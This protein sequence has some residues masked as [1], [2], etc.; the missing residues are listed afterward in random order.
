[1]KIAKIYTERSNLKIDRPFSYFISDE[2]NVL[3]GTRVNINFNGSDIVGYVEDIEYSD[4]SK[5]EYEDIQGFELKE[6]SDVIDDKPLLNKELVDLTHYL[7]KTTLSS[8]I[9]CYQTILPPSLRPNSYKKVNIK[10]NKAVR[11]INNNHD[12]T[13]LNEKDLELISILDKEPYLVDLK[14]YLSNIKRLEKL[15][16]VEKF[17]KEVLRNPLDKNYTK[18]K[19]YDLTNEQK[20]VIDEINNSNDQVYL[21]EGVTGSGKTEVYI[22]LSKEVLEQGKNVLVL[23]PEVSLTSQMVQRYMERFDYEIAIFHSKLSSGEKY[24]EYRRIRDDKVRIVIGARSACF[25]P[26]NNIGLII[27]D[28]EHSET[29]KQDDNPSYNM[30]DVILERAK[31][32]NAKVILGSATPSIESKTYAIKGIYHQ[33]YLNTRI[34]NLGLPSVS[35]VDMKEEIKHKNYSMFSLALKDA[36]NKT[37]DNNKQVILLLNRRGY[38]TNIQCVSCGYVFKCDKCDIPLRYHQKDNKLKCHYCGRN[39]IK[40]DTC[41]KCGSDLIRFIGKGS[42]KLEEEV[43][44]TFKNAKVA[45]LDL[46]STKYKGS[47]DKTLIEFKNHQYNVLVGTQIISKGLDF[48]D[49]DLVGIINA[50]ESLYYSDFRSN[51]K[52]YQLFTQ[53][54]G[55]SGRGENLGQAIIQTYS[56][57]NKT[58]LYAASQDY[59]SFYNDEMKYRYE[60]S[61]PPYYYL[62]SFTIS[63][64]SKDALY[65]YAYYLKNEIIKNMSNDQKLLGPTIPY[66]SKFNNKYKYRFILK[67]KDKNKANSL[68][69]YIR[70]LVLTSNIDISFDTSPYQNL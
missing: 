33:L 67:Y 31:Y 55:R 11:L 37:L 23:I 13:K 30:I 46:D 27:V 57:L 50:D 8:L 52:A 1:M 9:S 25:A 41:P 12:D 51:E 34:N 19:D 14:S 5:K 39:I 4:L 22:R 15:N 6:I 18:I 68:L 36:I 29:Y 3:V 62:A 24:D 48:S 26:L 53:V 64:S 40:P 54:V 21:L 44:K 60:M 2:L 32:H 16:I 65:K 7:A 49:V 56:P 10:T 43:I 17:D 28:E 38:S 45:R 20:E 47:L 66:L 35:I 70:D 63:S 59:K 42:E 58:I 61:Y 69:Q